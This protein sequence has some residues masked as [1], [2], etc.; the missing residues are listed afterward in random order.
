MNEVTMQRLYAFGRLGVGAV[1]T[2]AGMFG[3]TL[4]P[5]LVEIVITVIIVL[6]VGGYVG[7]RDNNITKGRIAA[8]GR[9][10]VIKSDYNSNRRGKDDEWEDILDDVFE[11]LDTEDDEDDEDVEEE[12]NQ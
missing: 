8:Q 7:Y 9:V 4:D 1:V 5:S 11:V 3:M 2:A 6:G 10:E 12:A